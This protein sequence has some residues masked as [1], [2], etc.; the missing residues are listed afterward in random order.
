MA[1]QDSTDYAI[2]V[3][4]YVDICSSRLECVKEEDIESFST[5]FDAEKSLFAQQS[6]PFKTFEEFAVIDLTQP[7]SSIPSVDAP[8][9]E[10]KTE[11]SV[12]PSPPAH[13][14]I[15]PTNGSQYV[16]SPKKPLTPRRTTTMPKVHVLS[17]IPIEKPAGTQFGES[18]DV[19]TTLV[20]PAAKVMP[21]SKTVPSQK[22]ENAF[23]KK[24]PNLKNAELG[25]PID[26][27]I[28]PG[29]SLGMKFSYTASMINHIKRNLKGYKWDPSKKMWSV[30]DASVPAA[31]HMLDHLGIF[32]PP[33][34]R[35]YAKKVMGGKMS[36]TE[37]SQLDGSDQARL[38]FAYDFD[39]ISTIKQLH[40]MER[41]WD[42]TRGSW[43][44][45]VGAVSEL[46]QLLSPLGVSAP[47]GLMEELRTMEI[48]EEVELHKEEVEAELHK[49]EVPILQPI[50]KQK[51]ECDCGRPH[52]EVKGRHVCK[53]FGH[54]RCN[55]GH[56][57]SSGNCWKG[58]SQQCSRCQTD[59]FPWKKDKLSGTG[60]GGIPSQR[61]L[62]NV[63]EA[64][65]QLQRLAFQGDSSH[66]I[67]CVDHS[68]EFFCDAL[69][70]SRL[71]NRMEP[72]DE[73]KRADI[74]ILRGGHHDPTYQDTHAD[75]N[76]IKLLA[77]GAASGAVS[78]TAVAPLA[79]VTILFMVSSM[80]KVGLKPA[81]S[82]GTWQALKATYEN[83][84]FRGF[85]KGNGTHFI[86]KVPFAAIKFYSYE[87]FKQDAKIWRRIVAGAGA[88]V[89]SGE[90]AH[91][92]KPANNQNT[93]ESTALSQPSREKK[94][95]PSGI[96]SVIPYIALN[97]SI[98]E[99]LK[100]TMSERY[101]K[102]DALTSAF[103]GAL[104]GSIASALTFP[105]D[106]I[107]RHIQLNF[108]KD[109][110]YTGYRDAFV[111]IYQKRGL[112]GF[113]KGLFPHFL[114][115]IPVVSISFGTYDF[116]K[117]MFNVTDSLSLTIRI[118]VNTQS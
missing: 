43:F 91:V 38:D 32:V 3:D 113:Y 64:G 60:S 87:R 80:E 63:Q 36:I 79:R 45:D 77:C 85:Y 82:K 107:R 41:M 69:R 95:S 57:W 6:V 1:K 75:E 61:P 72:R 54:F 59:V 115:V 102:N 40:P 14:S 78:R 18:A 73:K 96:E 34:V 27:T 71:A 28:L 24:Y 33:A 44:V 4:N 11:S 47:P 90:E 50:K 49:E 2:C 31:V 104:S 52:F 55:C 76:K 65:T 103:C 12:T 98:W 83:E 10:I 112:R 118:C 105:L 114:S 89:V 16:S 99:N 51:T 106:V 62:W 111:Q 93:G 92:C 66:V 13:I 110:S 7:A 42:A 19:V 8:L 86:K 109:A 68:S 23:A 15:A 48:K 84:G 17:R 21:T 30:I 46:I 116:M 53:Y 81:Y 88:A 101:Q 58:E 5:L 37:H 70:V 20:S 35:N 74:M 56:W 117:K 67:I 100:K 29:G 26:Y 39:V 9:P 94:G 22:L 25:L 97:L 108:K